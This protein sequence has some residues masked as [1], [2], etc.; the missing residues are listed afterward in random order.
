MS[1]ENSF[2]DSESKESDPDEIEPI[3]TEEFLEE[4]QASRDE[5]REQVAY[6]WC[7]IIREAGEHYRDTRDVDAVAD[8]L[9][10]DI[11]EAQE[12]LTVYRLLFE[13]PPE[14]AAVI[15]TKAGRSFYALNS[16]VNEAIDLK[17]QDDT[18]EDLVREYVS[19][20]YLEYDVDKE[21]IGDPVK[22]KAPESSIELEGL[23]E[24][25]ADTMTVPSKAFAGLTAMDRVAKQFMASTKALAAAA[26][27]RDMNETLTDQLAIS[28]RS[29]TATAA[30]A[31]MNENI[32]ED[33]IVPT[34]AFAAAATIDDLSNTF[35]Q[36]LTVPTAEITAAAELVQVYESQLGALAASVQPILKHHEQLVEAVAATASFSDML[37]EVKFPES[38]LADL[39][40]IQPTATTTVGTAS[41]AE[42]SR[43]TVMPESVDLIEPSVSPEHNTVEPTEPV[44]DSIRGRSI[45]ATVDST[46][47]TP[48]T[49]STELIF[50]VPTLIVDCI[51]STGEVRVWFSELPQE[52]QTTVVNMMLISATL[53]VTR[54]L[55]L[56]ALVPF[57]APSIRRMIVTEIEEENE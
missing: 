52:H 24:A 22:Q 44:E 15:A 18:I 47:P 20:V 17:D 8:D 33:L 50:E 26:E 31:N 27:L 10:L 25:V 43:R 53:S 35:A 13:E 16:G 54:S 7:E 56:A 55:P 57:I 2:S 45:T 1:D 5:Q 40:A 19:A 11:D 42:V 51:L 4:M 49:V 9:Q 21:M 23:Q 29:L 3:D 46:L 32:A 39:A 37:T 48:E 34:D 30:V 12:A 6:E 14:T 41:R 28:T 38:V 36:Q